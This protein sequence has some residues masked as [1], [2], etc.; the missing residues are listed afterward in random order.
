MRDHT[1]QG[2]PYLECGI[3]AKT[4]RKSIASLQRGIWVCPECID[5]DGPNESR[6]GVGGN[7]NSQG[8]F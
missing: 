1:H 6:I 3:C 5:E 4:I 7:D 2:S 8:Y